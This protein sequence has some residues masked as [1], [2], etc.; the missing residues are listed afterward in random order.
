VE[1]EEEQEE[2]EIDKD[3]DLIEQWNKKYGESAATGPAVASGLADLVTSMIKKRKAAEKEQEIFGGL[4]KPENIPLLVN[5]RVNAEVWRKMESKTKT[6]DIR[7][8]KVG[9][10]LVHTMMAN[11]EMATNLTKLKSMALPG[12]SRK[13]IKDSMRTALTAMQAG[14]SGLQEVNQRRRDC[15][16]EELAPAYK[17]LC[18]IPA[19]EGALLFGDDLGKQVKA[20][21]DATTISAQIVEKPFLGRGRD[22]FHPWK[23]MR[24][25]RE[26]QGARHYSDRQYSD[27]SYSDRQ[28]SDR[29]YSD[30]QYSNRQ[31]PSRQYQRSAGKSSRGKGKPYRK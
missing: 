28:Y 16:R 23:T 10:Q 2:G 12:D 29:Q 4:L 26:D 14:A 15:I 24:S 1:S 8:A 19:E 11:V 7:L 30:R 21:T 20:L 5:P 31:S 6:T 22:R 17:S 25:S 13:I 27:R 9:Q 3:D 18:N